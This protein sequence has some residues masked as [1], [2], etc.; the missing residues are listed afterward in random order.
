MPRETEVAD[1]RLALRGQ[2]NVGGLDR[3]VDD[4]VSVRVGETLAGSDDD[5]RGLSGIDRLAAGGMVERFSRHVFHDQIVQPVHI[6]GIENPD[7]A[8]V[9]E[10]GHRFHPGLERSPERRVIT[11]FARNNPDR[12]IAV[13][14]ALAGFVNRTRGSP[15]DQAFEFERGKKAAIESSSESPSGSVD[16]AAR[17]IY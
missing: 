16:M 6:T 11:L 5:L 8:G 3:A 4:S 2:E 1:L 7:Q 15:G 12:D 14:R 17:E 9:G 13:E 10:V